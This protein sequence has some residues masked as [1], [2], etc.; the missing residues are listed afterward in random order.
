[1]QFDELGEIHL[2]Y[3]KGLPGPYCIGTA[4]SDAR[5]RREYPGDPFSKAEYEAAVEKMA[6]ICSCGGEFKFKA[7]VRCPK[8]HSRSIAMG[9]I[10]V[11][12]D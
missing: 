7:P 10:T 3:L 8:C 5:V 2:R 6:G 1:M 11:H 4:E 9:D 12:Y